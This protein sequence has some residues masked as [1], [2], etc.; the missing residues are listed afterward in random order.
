[1]IDIP[2][3]VIAALTNEEWRIVCEQLDALTYRNRHGVPRFEDLLDAL[4]LEREIE[5]MD[6]FENEKSSTKRT[7]K[8]IIIDRKGASK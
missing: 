7:T 1:M 2:M 6:N 3:S 4:A 8:K 5:R